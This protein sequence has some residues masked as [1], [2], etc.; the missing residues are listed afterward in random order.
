MERNAIRAL[1]LTHTGALASLPV[2]DDA[3]LA[4]IREGVRQ[5]RRSCSGLTRKDRRHLDDFMKG[6]YVQGLRLFV[7]I[8]RNHCTDPRDATALWDRLSALTVAAH[9]ADYTVQE[10]YGLETFANY[11]LNDAQDIHALTPSTGTVD[12]IVE[13]SSAQEVA[14]SVLRHAVIRQRPALVAVGR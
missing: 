6:R 7:E 5:T 9:V 8:T 13:K 2:S 10:A 11:E 12:R 3:F 4:A 1:D 14:T